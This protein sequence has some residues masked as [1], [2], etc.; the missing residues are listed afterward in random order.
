M[1]LYQLS[2]PGGHKHVPFVYFNNGQTGDDRFCVVVTH[3]RIDDVQRWC[4]KIVAYHGSTAPLGRRSGSDIATV[5]AG[6]YSGVVLEYMRYCIVWHG[7]NMR[8]VC[9]DTLCDV[10][11]PM[12][13]EISKGTA[14]LAPATVDV[15]PSMVSTLPTSR[16]RANRS[17]EIRF[18]TNTHGTVRL[19]ISTFK[20]PDLR[21]G[22]TIVPGKPVS[23]GNA[24]GATVRA[25]QPSRFLLRRFLRT[26]P[27]LPDGFRA[28]QDV[29]D[30]DYF[31]EK[32]G[33]FVGENV[34]RTML[35]PR[36]GH[37][38]RFRLEIKQ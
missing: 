2:I 1:P 37:G 33:F 18:E 16:E 38:K 10:V 5:Q 19:R 35:V 34:E 25:I 3:R 29:N 20:D 4:E 27:P 12:E 21:N 36:G 11:D 31:E 24:F 14:T 23:T 8:V 28:I 22:I 17:R 32:V 9:M 15:G 13:Q 30:S 6:D 26:P 7:A